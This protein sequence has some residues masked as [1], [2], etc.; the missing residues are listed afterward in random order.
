MSFSRVLGAVLNYPHL[1]LAALGLQI[2]LAV[3]FVIPSYFYFPF[4]SGEGNIL[5]LFP[6]LLLCGLGLYVLAVAEH[7][8]HR[9][10]TVCTG[11]LLILSSAAQ[12][13]NLAIFVQILTRSESD[14]LATAPSSWLSLL[15]PWSLCALLAWRSGGVR[16]RAILNHFALLLVICA[17][18][19]PGADDPLFADC[20]FYLFSSVATYSLFEFIRRTE[21]ARHQSLS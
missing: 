15:I 9:Y 17:L 19:S 21:L 20:Y 8:K 10:L 2:S 7:S 14:F 5:S 18:L 16:L 13:Y 6:V 11:W 1:V 3:C 4:Q 12:L